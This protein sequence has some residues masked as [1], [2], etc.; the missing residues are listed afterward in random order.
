MPTSNVYNP[1]SFGTI[2]GTPDPSGLAG[3]TTDVIRQQLAGNLAPG[4]ISMY[5]QQAAERGGGTG[6]GVDS[7]ATNSALERML[8][9]TA[10]QQA[11]TGEQ[12]SFSQQ[13][14]ANQQQQSQQQLQMQQE[15]LAANM[16]LDYSQ[17]NERQQEFVNSQAQQKCPLPFL[18]F[19]P[20]PSQPHKDHERNRN[21]K[22][23]SIPRP[24]NHPNRYLTLLFF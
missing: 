10:E 13:G 18:E 2:A 12:A 14:I 19:E 15:T 21:T 17:L 5:R 9:L 3:Q 20:Y 23:Y 1:P 22:Q 24:H 8:G 7:A 6:F 4:T 16:G 11:Q